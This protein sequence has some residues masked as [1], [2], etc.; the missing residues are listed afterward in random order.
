MKFSIRDILWL[1]ILVAAG[2]TW[3]LEHRSGVRMQEQL[4]QQAE[5]LQYQAQFER[6]QRLLVETETVM[7]RRALESQ[8]HD[9]AIEAKAAM[10]KLGQPSP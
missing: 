8:A 4:R 2:V 9:M 5:Q 7:E 10:E 3:W 6:A 1:T